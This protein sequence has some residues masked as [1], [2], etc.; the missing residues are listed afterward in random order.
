MRS[1]YQFKEGQAGQ[2]QL[3]TYLFEKLSCHI[4]GG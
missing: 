4:N 2:L 3:A 1:E